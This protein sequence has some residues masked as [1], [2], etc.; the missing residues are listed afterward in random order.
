M[1]IVKT[2]IFVFLVAIFQVTF[3]PKIALFFALPNFI[4]ILA[5]LS[6]FQKD[7]KKALLW[8]LFGGFLLDIFSPNPFLNMLSLFLVVFL[9]QFIFLRYFE[10]ENIYLFLAYCFFGSLLNDFFLILLSN[11]TKFKMNL[12]LKMLFLDALYT[13]FFGFIFYLIYKYL[14]KSKSHENF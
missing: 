3:L 1:K 4:L 11:L 9:A 2:I 8:A 10:R 14:E 6:V 7:F 5:I 13:T 12:E